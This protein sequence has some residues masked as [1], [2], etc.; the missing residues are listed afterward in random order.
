MLALKEYQKRA[1]ESLS[2]F[3]KA[4]VAAGDPVPA[5]SQETR[6]QFGKG[7]LHQGGGGVA[8]RHAVRVLADADGRGE[9]AGGVP[10]RRV[11]APR[12]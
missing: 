2:R 10:R 11:G 5:F 8:G 4:T 6:R 3:F 1:L 9:N 7:L 12:L